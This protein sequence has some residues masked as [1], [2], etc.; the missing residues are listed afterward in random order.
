[1]RILLTVK[2]MNKKYIVNI[3]NF[4]YIYFTLSFICADIEHNNSNNNKAFPI[5]TKYEGRI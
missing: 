4:L 5:K 3:D 2:K 1:M